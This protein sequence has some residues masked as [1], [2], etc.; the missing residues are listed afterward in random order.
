MTPTDS[1]SEPR[2]LSPVT[3]ALWVLAA[4]VSFWSF[5]FT[6]MRGSDLWWHLAAGRAIWESWAWPRTDAWSFTA[7]GRPWILHEGIAS[8]VYHLWASVLGHDTLVWW[9][10]AVLVTAF[11][12]LFLLLWRLTSEAWPAYLAALLALAIGAP[13][14]DLRPQLYTVLGYVVL[15]RLTLVDAPRWAV[16]LLFLCWVNLHGGFSFGLIALA[17]LLSTEIDGA[18]TA[19][20]AAALWV[21]AAVVCL[22]N[23]HGIDAFRP[24]LEYAFDSTSPFR[25]L[26][27]WRP[28]LQPGG[29][30]SWL[31]APSI[32]VFVGAAV[33]GFVMKL[34]RDSRV[35]TAGIALTGAT[36]AM[37]LQ[38]RRIVPLFGISL[39][40]ALAP[41]L[42]RGV[43]VLRAR[44]VPAVQLA[45]PVVA[46]A[47]GIAWLAPYPLASSHA[48]HY[49]T[50]EYTFP[51]ETMNFVEVNRI[52]GN[53]F[54]LY[55]WG[56]YVDL[57]TAGRLRVFI[58]G[59]AD[60]VFSAGTYRDYL[61][62]LGRAPGWREIVERSGANYVL[63]PRA[64]PGHTAELLESGLWRMLYHDDVSVLLV[65]ASVA[66]PP[67][68]VVTRDS[69][70]RRL[71]LGTDA[72]ARGQLESAEA[73]YAGA[74]ALVP[75]LAP[76]CDGL[77][78]VQ[79]G[80][81]DRERARHTVQRCQAMFP[82]P[83]RGAAL[84]ALVGATSSRP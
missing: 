63:W 36:L 49:L 79:V 67:A 12:L 71:A 8:V 21:A 82:D 2:W 78:H 11:V 83:A 76:A 41:V 43:S 1:R 74:L 50:G 23:P 25:T 24:T 69:A 42:A 58:D 26:E 28:P 40:L 20:R 13:F 5:G 64:L 52:S 60:R 68:L 46:L 31:Y 38:H 53:V 66:S 34:H 17:I 6:T 51:I 56:G 55:N 10:W 81:A 48:F 73:Y 84:R 61:R 75:Y 19:W 47:I 32:A 45:L 37:S 33:A 72:Y 15:L 27:E 59:R 7:A 14:F 39:S 65:G 30:Q 35:W 70:Y 62:V 80:R 16:L 57:R 3:R 9:K 22:L 54:A 4:S 44:L 18:R 29:I 77:V